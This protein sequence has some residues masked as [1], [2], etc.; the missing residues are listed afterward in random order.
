MYIIIERPLDA[1]AQEEISEVYGHF[2]DPNMTRIYCEAVVEPENRATIM[3]LGGE[4]DSEPLEWEESEGKWYSRGTYDYE[5]CRMTMA[6]LTNKQFLAAM[7]VAM[8]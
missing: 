4:T 2:P 1:T 7:T 6:D 8:E 5:I 3:S